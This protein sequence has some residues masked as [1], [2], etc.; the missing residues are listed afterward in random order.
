MDIPLDEVVHFFVITRSLSGGVSDADSE[1]TFEVFEEATDTAI[2][3]GT[4]TKRTGKTGSYRGTSTLSAANGYEVGKWY[5]VTITA[6]VGGVTEKLDVKTFRVVAANGFIVPSETF[7]VVDQDATDTTLYLS[8][9]SASGPETGLVATN[10]TAWYVI[11]RGSEVEIPLSNLGTISDAHTDGGI[12][13]CAAVPGR[14]R[15]DI[16]DGPA[17]SGGVHK[18]FWVA[19]KKA[20]AYIAMATVQIRDK[21]DGKTELQWRQYVGA[22]AA[23]KIVVSLDGLTNTIY[24]LDGTTVHMV[25]TVAATG[26]RTIV[27]S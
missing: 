14:Y 1:P 4:T 18:Y 16:P 20:G 9:M 10:V 12:I 27:Y 22:G 7:A 24:G 3:S 23:G 2:L 11:P 8:A 21:V 6:T 19:L 26:A 17:I 5:Q 13:E 25:A 15:L